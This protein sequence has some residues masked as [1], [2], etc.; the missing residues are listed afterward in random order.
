MRIISFLFNLP[1]LPFMLAYQF[2]VTYKLVRDND[3]F[4]LDDIDSEEKL[5]GEIKP[6]VDKMYETYKYAFHVFCILF[7]ITVFRFIC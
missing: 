4:K 2:Y 6:Y 1:I 3:E 7:W 5:W